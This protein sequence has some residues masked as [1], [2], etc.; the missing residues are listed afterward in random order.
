MDP[1]LMA[2]LAE[3]NPQDLE[4]IGKVLVGI[5]ISTWISLVPHFANIAKTVETYNV[6]AQKPK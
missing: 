3:K 6:A 5:P 1:Q 4:A 2:V